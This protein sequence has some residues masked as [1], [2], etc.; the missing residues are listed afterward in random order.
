MSHANT[1]P[2]LNS[3]LADYQ[4]LYQKLRTYHWTVRGPHFFE[5]HLK[6]EELYTE[7]ALR[8]DDLAERIL[9][10]HGEP[11]ATLAA[12]LAEARLRE[13][14]DPGDA[15]SMVAALADDYDALNVHLR[16]AVSE[17]GEAGDDATVN[18]LEDM[19]DVQEKTVWM[20]RAFLGSP[21]RATPAPAAVS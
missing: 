16:A 7:A 1:V 20:L 12:Q 3:L 6:F 5:L 8:V 11:L 14:A 2:T 19:A 18:L 9:A 13:D 10:L 17:A 21:R 4:V 15:T